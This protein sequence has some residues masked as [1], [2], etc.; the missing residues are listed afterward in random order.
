[1]EDAAAAAEI[2]L[3]QLHH[4]S[5]RSSKGQRSVQEPSTFSLVQALEAATSLHPSMAAE[6]VSGVQGH[7]ERR[8][9]RRKKNTAPAAAATM[10]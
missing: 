8:R 1:M 3:L 2:V 7:A 4:H 6:V 5:G 10:A 9:R